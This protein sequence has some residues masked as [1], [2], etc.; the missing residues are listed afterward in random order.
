MKVPFLD[1]RV[2][3]SSERTDLLEGVSAVFDHGKFVMGPEVEQ[4]EAAIAKYCGRRYAVAVGSGTHA[5]WL[6]I[7]A[8]QL[9]PGE[10]II[11]TA[12]SWIA[13]ANAIA[14]A[15][16]TPVF[17]DIRDDLN[18]DPDSVQK[19]ISPR[20]RAI[21]PVHYTGKPCDMERLM[22]LAKCNNI[23]I[24]EDAAQAFGAT[25]R[26]R[27]VGSF[28][29]LAAFSM[30]PMKVLAACG[31]AGAIVTDD[32]SL[33]E[34]LE[35]LRYNGCINRELCIEPSL[36]GRIDTLQAA[37]LSRRLVRLP[38]LL[39]AR[40]RNAARYDMLLRG[41]VNTPAYSI[42]AEDVFYTYTILADNRDELRKFLDQHGIE[43]KIQHPY[44]MPDQPAYKTSIQDDLSRARN[45]IKRVLCLPIH[46]KLTDAQIDFVS[47]CIKMFYNNSK[48]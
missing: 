11:T 14:L 12:L 8:L 35:A 26:G 39:A 21:L 45:L 29:T 44:L 32:K 6:A 31:E 22:C 4:L 1:L 37:L 19:L 47:S 41:F 3:D 23:E 15:G 13:T 48:I 43:T 36:N 5:L 20:T 17:A 34:R 25:Y 18:I 27:Q 28:G 24:I 30:N 10:E 16:A 33:F 7:K 46:E 2:L 38:E 42:G 9:K 40:R